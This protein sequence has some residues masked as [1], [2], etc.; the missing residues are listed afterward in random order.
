MGVEII[1]IVDGYKKQTVWHGHKVI[2]PD[3]LDRD[4]DIICVATRKYEE[5]IME[6]I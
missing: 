3:E 6:Q 4:S 2:T 1:G 5:E